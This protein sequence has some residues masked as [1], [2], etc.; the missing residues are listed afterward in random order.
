V[1][2]WIG[3]HAALRVDIAKGAELTPE[4]IEALLAL[5]DEDVRTALAQRADTHGPLLARVYKAGGA[6][7]RD[8]VVAHPN[9]PGE[10]FVALADESDGERRHRVAHQTTRVDAQVMFAKHS[11]EQTRLSLAKNP[12]L[13]D[14]AQQILR[15]DP[16]LA[17]RAAAAR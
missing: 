7:A 1:V 13:T 3:A 14:A 9:V 5:N 10:V 8:A 12:Q 4:V 15:R 11:D 16:S 17:V 6:R 2:R